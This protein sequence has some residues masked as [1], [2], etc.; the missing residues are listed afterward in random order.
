M[1]AFEIAFDWVINLNTISN[2]N[3]YYT[4]IWWR[5]DKKLHSLWFQTLFNNENPAVIFLKQ[6]ILCI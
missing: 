4:I 2:F 6:N 3:S 5:N 1:K